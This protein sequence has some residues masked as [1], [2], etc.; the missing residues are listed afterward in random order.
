MVATAAAVANIPVQNETPEIPPEWCVSAIA[1]FGAADPL[2][3][4]SSS[5]SRA[6]RRDRAG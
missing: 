1:D 6:G 5:R 4:D 3:I 2:Q